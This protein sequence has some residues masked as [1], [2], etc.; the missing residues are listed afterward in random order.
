MSIVQRI[1][2]ID[3]MH[4]TSSGPLLGAHSNVVILKTSSL[5]AVFSFLEI[6]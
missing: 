6:L 3:Y 5:P 1:G 4:D 2:G